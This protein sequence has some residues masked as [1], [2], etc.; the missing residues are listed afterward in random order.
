MKNVVIVDDEY[1]FAQGV[2]SAMRFEGFS[3]TVFS[4]ASEALSYFRDCPGNFISDDLKI[5]I[6]ISLAPGGDLITF[7]QTK[8]SNFE[9]TGLV[10]ANILLDDFQRSCVSS[11]IV[12]YTAHFAGRNWDLIR[13]FCESRQVKWWPK[14]A[15]PNV[16]DLVDMVIN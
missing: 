14:T 13:K 15:N 5:F 3:A 6:D 2:A 16:N 11:C 1:H 7:S 4:N 8:T 9:L 10:L 12:L